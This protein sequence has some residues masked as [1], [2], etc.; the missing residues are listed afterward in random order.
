MNR[1]AAYLLSVIIFNA[2][3]WWIWHPL[4]VAVAILTIGRFR[5]LVRRNALFWATAAV[6]TIGILWG[7]AMAVGIILAADAATASKAVRA[8]LLAEGFFAVG[9]VGFE[10]APEDLIMFN[11]AGQTAAV[12]MVCYV[13]TA[14]TAGLIAILR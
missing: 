11:K 13:L 6:L 10:P 9:Y 5:E 1:K 7:V 3:V 4:G 14:A 2:V 8:L 12:G